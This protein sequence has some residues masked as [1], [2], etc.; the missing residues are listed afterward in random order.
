MPS[1][2]RAVNAY[3]QAAETLAPLTQIVLLYD[4]AIRRIKEARQAIEARRIAD[5]H[6]AIDK[7]TAI[8]EALHACLDHE[9]GGEIA[10]NLD[11]LYTYIEFR[12]QRVNLTSDPSICDELIERLSEL[13]A[14]WARL[15]ESPPASPAKDATARQGRPVDPAR[16]ALTI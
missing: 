3:G 16:A 9:R 6:V 11:Q 13:R 12:L 10:R 2:Q 8:V 4:G 1:M 5:R 7:A 15:A 14:S